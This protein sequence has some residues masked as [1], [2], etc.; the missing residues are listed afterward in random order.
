MDDLRVAIIFV[1][2]IEVDYSFSTNTL[3]CLE[4][5]FLKIQLKNYVHS[6]N[7]YFTPTMQNM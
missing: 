2:I 4:F 5:F 7:I 3:S 6:I 1:L